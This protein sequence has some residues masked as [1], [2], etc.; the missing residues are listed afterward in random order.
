MTIREIIGDF[1]VRDA[2]TNSP[3]PI[4]RDDVGDKLAAKGIAIRN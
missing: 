3:K 2:K 1:M 4:T